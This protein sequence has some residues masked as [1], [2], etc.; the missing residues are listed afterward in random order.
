MG[1]GEPGGP[2]GTGKRTI[3]RTAHR[4]PLT[5]KVNNSNATQ[6]G[7]IR[8]EQGQ[9]SQHRTADST[10]KQHSSMS[11]H[12]SAVD[13]SQAG[14]DST[15]EKKTPDDVVVDT[16]IQGKVNKHRRTEELLTFQQ[17]RLKLS[18]CHNR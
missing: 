16:N 9:R 13:Q 4:V 10:Q 7:W 5:L 18:N 6:T 1:N 3:N 17:E 15:V 11:N 12:L 14:L 8:C 2:G